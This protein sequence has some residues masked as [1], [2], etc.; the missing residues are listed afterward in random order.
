MWEDARTAF[1]VVRR[2]PVLMVV[3]MASIAIVVAAVTVFTS[4]VQGLPFWQPNVHS[5]EQLRTIEGGHSLG[6]RISYPDFQDY[7]EA[8]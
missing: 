6:G 1:R 2:F 8:G 3:A 4:V 7:R 5:P